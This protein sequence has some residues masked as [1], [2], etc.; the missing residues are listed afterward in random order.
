MTFSGIGGDPFNGTDFIDCLEVFLNDPATEGIILIGEI[1]GNAEENAAEFLKQHNSVSLALEQYSSLLLNNVTGLFWKLCLFFQRLIFWESM[2][3]TIKPFWAGP[4]ELTTEQTS[5]SFWVGSFSPFPQCLF[6]AASSYPGVTSH[7]CG[8]YVGLLLSGQPFR[9][10]A[11]KPS[12]DLPV[13]F[14]PITGI[15]SL[16]LRVYTCTLSSSTLT[17]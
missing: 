6:S 15:L 7:I 8:R 5:A 13:H 16:D 12:L 17:F 1:G 2:K 4:L 10:S 14:P 9:S 11:W 3:D